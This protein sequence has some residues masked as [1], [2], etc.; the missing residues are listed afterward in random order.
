MWY[1]VGTQCCQSPVTCTGTRCCRS[2]EEKDQS[3]PWEPNRHDR[4]CPLSPASGVKWES[5]YGSGIVWLERSLE[6]LSQA[7]PVGPA[8]ASHLSAP[9]RAKLQDR[10]QG[11]GARSQGTQEGPWWQTLQPREAEARGR[12]KSDLRG[13]W[14]MLGSSEVILRETRCSRRVSRRREECS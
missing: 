1:T 8:P 9:G 6:M 14:C 13:P 5:E 3:V 7:L 11:A 10:L 2:P 4:R 12:W